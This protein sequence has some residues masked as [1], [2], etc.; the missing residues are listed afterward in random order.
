MDND[1]DAVD[2]LLRAL[3]AKSQECEELCGELTELMGEWMWA[4]S[5]NLLL[6]DVCFIK[7]NKITVLDTPDGKWELSRDGKRLCVADTIKQAVGV[8][9]AFELDA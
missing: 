8:V 3:E 7:R 2:D 5:H 9:R 4:E 1:G 6:A